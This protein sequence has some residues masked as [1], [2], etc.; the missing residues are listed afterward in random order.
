[1]VLLSIYILCDLSAL[2]LTEFMRFVQDALLE[3]SSELWWFLFR[4]GL[5]NHLYKPVLYF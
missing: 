4:L 1:M 2:C 3:G 5:I